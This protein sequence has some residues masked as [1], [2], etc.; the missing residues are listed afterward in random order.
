LH[1]KAKLADIRV[2]AA[3]LLKMPLSEKGR[4]DGIEA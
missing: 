3:Q 2:S 4:L 1:G